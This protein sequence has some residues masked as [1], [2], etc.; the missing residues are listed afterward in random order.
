[1]KEKLRCRG[2]FWIF[3]MVTVYPYSGPDHE[4]R[5]NV[6]HRQERSLL[7]SLLSCYWEK[8]LPQVMAREF[9]AS[10]LGRGQGRS[11]FFQLEVLK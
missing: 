6:N 7:E 5:L 2:T 10:M 1:M 4:Q 3:L 9:A 11:R 8:V